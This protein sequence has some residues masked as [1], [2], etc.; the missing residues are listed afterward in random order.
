MW[1]NR[2]RT[3]ITAIVA[4]IKTEHV[5]VP[6]GTGFTPVY[7]IVALLLW[8]DPG[9]RRQYTFRSKSLARNPRKFS[10]GSGISVLVDPTNPGRGYRVEV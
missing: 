7:I 2:Q 5:Q 8:T 9:T 4:D 1:F 3:R 6:W 10:R